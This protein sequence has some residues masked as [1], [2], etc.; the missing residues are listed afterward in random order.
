VWW[1]SNLIRTERENCCDDLVVAV[2][3]DAHEYAVALAALAENRWAAP[4]IALA[5]TGGSLLKRIRRLLNKQPEGPRAAL[6][7]VL[8]ASLIVLTFGVVLLAYQSAKAPVQFAQAQQKAGPP[9]QA[10]A[11][12]AWDK[13]LKEDVAYIITNEERN[14]FRQLGTDEEREHFIEQ[15]WLRRD[16]TPGTPDNEF[17]E[18]HYRR[19]AYANGRFT[20]PSGLPGWKTD[21]GRIYITFGPPDEIDSYPSGGGGETRNHPLEAW[22]YQFIEGIGN[23]VQMEFIDKDNTGDYHMTMDPRGKDAPLYVPRQ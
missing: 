8:T 4:D 21:R 14:A 23:D 12:S 17:K 13:W 16:P 6:T 19:I 9:A 11:E 18:E 1:I 15:F 2:S 7:P 20:T 3:G 22:R 10:P 5:A